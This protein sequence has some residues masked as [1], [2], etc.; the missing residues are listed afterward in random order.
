[1]GPNNCG[2]L[3]VASAEEAWNGPAF[4]ACRQRQLADTPDETCTPCIHGDRYFVDHIGV[5]AGALAAGTVAPAK[6]GNF[7]EARQGFLA[8]KLQLDS[9][10][11][12]I[13]LDLSS[14]CRLRCRK[15]YVYNLREVPPLGDMSWETFQ[16][17]APLFPHAIQVSCTGIGEAVGNP[18]FLEMI[19]V[20]RRHH[21]FV[22]FTTS[23]NPLT[24]SMCEAL[25]EE[26][27]HE[28]GWSI[29]SL[30]EDL[31]RYHHRGGS[32]EKV[33]ENL[34]T[35]QRKKRELHSDVPVLLWNFLA[36]RSNLGE[37]P[38]VLRYAA[39]RGFQAL[40]VG[41]LVPAAPGYC[42]AYHEFYAEENPLA[43]P[44]ERRRLSATLQ[45][46]Q[47]LASTLGVSF[48]SSHAVAVE[49]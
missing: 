26:G 35:I 49:P 44:D 27:A 4:R 48:S 47:Q 34:A 9:W 10:P 12:V 3:S 37:L 32:L 39:E 23:G 5:F 21:C 25:V 18:H 22:S 11:Y 1:M 15:C 42:Q 33:L 30:N 8:G 13:F 19:R 29:D 7:E 45:E 43:T 36:M 16:K 38:D 20:I 31:Y 2:D 46:A 14:R 24:T 6:R 41:A 28:I 40:H 17:V